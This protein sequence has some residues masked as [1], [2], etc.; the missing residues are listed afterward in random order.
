MELIP[1]QRQWQRLS[2]GRWVTQYRDCIS[3]F[4][5]W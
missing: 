2:I 3:L 1:K 5:L 4:V